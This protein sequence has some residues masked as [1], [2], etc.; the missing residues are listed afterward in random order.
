MNVHSNVQYNKHKHIYLVVTV[1][2]FVTYK[3][4]FMRILFSLVE[5]K[6][7]TLGS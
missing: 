1:L 6:N 2:I 5:Y 7:R 4:V 3:Y